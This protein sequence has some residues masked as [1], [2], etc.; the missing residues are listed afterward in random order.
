MLPSLTLEPPAGEHVHSGSFARNSF[1][2]RVI[3]T[4][5]VQIVAV[6]LRVNLEARSWT[7]ERLKRLASENNQNLNPVRSITAA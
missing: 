1:A 3:L 2:K 5:T 6:H 4:Y 7:N